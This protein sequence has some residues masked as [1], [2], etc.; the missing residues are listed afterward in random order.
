MPV[1][2]LTALNED[3]TLFRDTVREFARKEIAPRVREMDEASRL[4][5][6]LLQQC[7]ELGL[8]G[9]EIPEEYGGQGGSFFQA[10]LA[11]EELA[12]VDPALSVVVINEA[13]DKPQHRGIRIRI[14][15]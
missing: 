15:G 14:A 4:Q 1:R 13:F 9:L 6:S 12:A 10:L 8:M 7:F 3:D 11:I 2:P 5:P